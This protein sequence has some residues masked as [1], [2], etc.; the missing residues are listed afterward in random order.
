MQTRWKRFWVGMGPPARCLDRRDVLAGGPG[1]QPLGV[2]LRRLL[3]LL[4]G[5]LYGAGHRPCQDV[6]VW[7]L[8][9]FAVAAVV[10]AMACRP[11]DGNAWWAALGFGLLLAHLVFVRWR[12]RRGHGHK[13]LNSR[14][15]SRN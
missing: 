8:L 3:P 2:R 12:G 11:Q 1:R 13:V 4:A 15:V 10:V 6:A 14:L 9:A 7:A 5:E